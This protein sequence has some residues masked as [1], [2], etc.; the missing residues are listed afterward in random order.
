M[1]KKN[2]REYKTALE[3]INASGKL[4]LIHEINEM[5]TYKSQ[6]RYDV[7]YNLFSSSLLLLTKE[8]LSNLLMLRYG[9]L[10]R[11]KT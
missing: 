7:V 2:S 8:F 10:E 3:K 1:E 6:A 11:L 5:V 9:S 4:K